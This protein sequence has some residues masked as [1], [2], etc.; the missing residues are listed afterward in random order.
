MK[1]QAL[2]DSTMGMYMS[3][4][5]TFELNP[6]NPIVKELLKG[7]VSYSGDSTLKDLLLLLFETAL[8]ISGFSLE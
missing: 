1:A 8:L 2:R 5:K 7:V 6:Y 4:R 3:S